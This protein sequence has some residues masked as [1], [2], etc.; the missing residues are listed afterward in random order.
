MPE[1]SRTKA[2]PRFLR[3]LRKPLHDKS[4]SLYVRWKR[5]LPRVPFPVRLPFGAWWIARD[6]YLASTL[7]YDG[8]EHAERVFVQRFLQP[9]MTVIDIGA[10]HGFYTLLMSKCVRRS[11]K[12]FAFEPSPRERRAL[13]LHL[14]LNLG[15]NVTVVS[16]GL[17][18][19][20]GTTDLYLAPLAYAGHNSLR[21]PDIPQQ[22]VTQRVRIYR[23]DSWLGDNRIGRVDFIKLDAEG[24][25]RDI[26]EGAVRLL[27]S[28]PRPVVL[29]EVEDRRTQPWGYPAREIVLAL[30]K[31]DYA[32]FELSDDAR[33]I[34]LESGHG[35]LQANLVAVPREMVDQVLL[36]VGQA[37]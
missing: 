16:A 4:R 29:A 20:N 36:R 6:D 30:D 37:C 13:Y 7:S 27:T 35:S 32:W 25:E 3:F 1:V 9:G 5:L 12:V 14:A 28:R 18:Q 11:G 19:T 15:T 31:I 17:G 21:V 2:L 34:P 8:F 24:G 22:T 10:H 33:L 23:L 26:L